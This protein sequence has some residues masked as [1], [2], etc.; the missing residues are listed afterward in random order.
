MVERLTSVFETIGLKLHRTVIITFLPGMAVLIT[1]DVIMRYVFDSPFIWG[2]EANGLMLLIVFFGC[3]TH[4]WTAKRHIRMELIY[5]K[6][7]GK[8][9]ILADI[10]ASLTGLLFFGMVA[11]QAFREIPHMI[12]INET[13]ETFLIPLWPFKLYMGL[14]SLLFSLL[15]LVSSLNL[16]FKMISKGDE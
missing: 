10:V 7:K 5:G 9:R 1:L 3:L 4:C 14:C 12:K 11:V 8:L 15:L 13:G 16:F 2:T 6:F